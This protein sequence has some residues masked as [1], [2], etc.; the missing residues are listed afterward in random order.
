MTGQNIM[1]LAHFSG[2]GVEYWLEQDGRECWRWYNEALK[3]YKE[4]NKTE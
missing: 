2:S 3:V 4:M 1:F